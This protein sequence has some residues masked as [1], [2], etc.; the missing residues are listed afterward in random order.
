MAGELGVLAWTQEE[1]ESQD[2]QVGGVSVLLVG[3]CVGDR[4]NGVDDDEGD[5]FFS[6]DRRILDP[7]GLNIPGDSHVQSAVGLGV[8]GLPGVWEASWEVGCRNSPPCLRNRL[9]PKSVHLALVV[10]GVSDAVP[11]DLKDLNSRD[12]WILESRINLEGGAE[13]APLLVE[14]LLAS[15]LCSSCSHGFLSSVNIMQ[16]GRS[17]GRKESCHKFCGWV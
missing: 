5:G 4:H 11:I 12:G 15:I 1:V 9:L 14:P 2:N 16:E 7:V 17:G 8:V 3:G 13:V 6:S 10:L